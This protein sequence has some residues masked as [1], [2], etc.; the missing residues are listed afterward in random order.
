MRGEHGATHNTSLTRACPRLARHCEALSVGAGARRVAFRLVDT[1]A[2]RVSGFFGYI[3]FD[4]A[5]VEPSRLE[6]M[7]AGMAAWGPDGGRFWHS[8]SAGLGQLVLASTPESVHENLPH[9]DATCGLAFTAAGRLDHREDL[10]HALDVPLAEQPHTSDG[11]LMRRAWLKWGEAAVQQLKGDWQ[12]AAWDARKRRLFVA[13]PANGIAAL[14]YCPLPHAFYFASCIKALLALPEIPK[15]PNLLR[16]AQVL[17][18]WPG[19]GTLCGYEGIFRLPPAHTLTL[20]DGR[21]TT[22]RYWFPEQMPPLVLGSDDDYVAAF[23]ELYT[24][25]VRSRLRSRRPIAAQLSGGLDSGSVCALAERELR[26]RGER[27]TTFTSV[28]LHPI[29]FAVK[30]RFFDER[31]FVEANLRHWGD[32]DGE[33]I[34]AEDVSPLAGSRE[35]LAA[36]DEP[37]HSPANW[38]WIHAIL[39]RARERGFGVMLTGQMGNG[40]VSYTGTPLNL[41][42]LLLSGQWGAIRQSTAHLEP[43][44]WLKVRRHLLG[45]ARRWWRRKRSLPRRGHEDWLDYSAIRP[46]FARELGLNEKMA[47]AGHDAS[48]LPPDGRTSQLLTLKLGAHIVGSLWAE[49]G[50][51]YGLEA[52]DATMDEALVEFCLRVPET[53]FRGA[54]TDRWLMR[55][56]LNGLLPDRVRLNRTRGSQAGDLTARVR[57][58]RGELSAAL[59]ALAAHPLAASVVDLPKLRRI[60]ETLPATADYS[61]HFQCVVVLLRGL[62]AGDFLLRF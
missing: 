49:T 60:L 9:C 1:H 51:H 37:G 33:F 42:P 43:G 56:S 2:R 26:A 46:G 19:D 48:F 24:R 44:G 20:V 52:R 45:P 25:A 40:A 57:T 34:Q 12:F 18:S 55:R 38:F 22:R 27:L 53:Q 17:T 8:G 13:Q 50:A 31:P 36:H 30:G 29:E 10:C 3:R 35:S 39:S 62:M 16:V 61:H 5:Q 59:D 28:P 58:S 7:R 15:H 14:Y 54:G 6:V 4:G 21:V 11:E 32:V 47:A 41:W 23:L